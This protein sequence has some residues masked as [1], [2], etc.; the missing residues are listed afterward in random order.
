MVWWRGWALA[1][2]E[3]TVRLC[4]ILHSASAGAGVLPI[5]LLL[6][7]IFLTCVRCDAVA[8]EIW[9]IHRI[10]DTT[11]FSANWVYIIHM[12][13]R[14]HGDLQEPFY[15]KT[16]RGEARIGVCLCCWWICT[17]PLRSSSQHW[18]LRL[19]LWNTKVFAPSFQPQTNP[20]LLLF[21]FR[22]HERKASSSSPMCRS[23]I[24]VPKDLV[25]DDIY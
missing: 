19:S 8:L 6:L 22:R 13:K 16:T 1:A 12:I 15:K 9:I 10:Y 5:V 18:F 21:S 7:C 2:R 23:H 24:Y 25:L 11:D 17:I 4:M 20:R 14:T 3:R